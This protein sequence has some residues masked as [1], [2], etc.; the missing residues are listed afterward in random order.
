VASCMRDHIIRYF[1]LPQKPRVVHTRGAPADAFSDE[2]VRVRLARYGRKDPLH[3]AFMRSRGWTIDAP[4]SE[5]GV[6]C[7]QY[8]HCPILNSTD[9]KD[10][11]VLSSSSCCRRSCRC[12]RRC[13]APA[14]MPG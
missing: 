5:K 2:A 14:A 12:R 6:R 3:A 1:P 13:W 11:L 10:M 7:L 4:V 9:T 8:I